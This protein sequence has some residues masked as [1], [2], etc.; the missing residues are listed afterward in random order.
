M[1][2]SFPGLLISLSALIFLVVSVVAWTFGWPW[3]DQVTVLLIAA[4]CL[5]VIALHLFIVI[6]VRRDSHDG[7]SCSDEV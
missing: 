5:A 2:T 7:S 1:K 4:A 3:L 6:H